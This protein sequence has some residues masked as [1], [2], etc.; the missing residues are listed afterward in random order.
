MADTPNEKPGSH[1]G[2]GHRKGGHG[3]HGG[4]HEEG[5]EG[6]PEWLISFAD[7]VALMMGFFVVLLAMNM[8]KTTVGGGGKKGEH[9]EVARDDSMLD[10]AIA[11]REAFNNPVDINSTDP[12]DAALV[13]RLMQRSGKSETR[14][15]GIK[16]HKQDVQAIRPSDYYAISGSV[17]FAE[18]SS[19]LLESGRGTISEIAKRARGLRL[20]IEVRG[21]TSS[22]ETARG[23]EM[24]MKLSADRAMVVARAL[25]SQGID[26]WQ[27]QLV[28]CADHD[29]LEAFPTTR[30][31]D[32]ANARVEI[33]LTDQ[34]VPDQV[35]TRYEGLSGDPSSTF[36]PN[37][38]I[39]SAP[40]TGPSP[41]AAASANPTSGGQ[42][43]SN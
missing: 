36:A 38:G 43:T 40:A 28:I 29:R 32:K 41:H 21:H 26:W 15:P 24:A 18:N 25:A 33:I 2:E 13:R 4:G 6:A 39:K 12:H 22:V 37:T 23:P 3:A 27:M 8:A 10:F 5:H 31:A 34:V 20:V 30:T 35:P 42:G 14:D 11:V 7:N 17:P 1:D 19:E 9:G 16:G